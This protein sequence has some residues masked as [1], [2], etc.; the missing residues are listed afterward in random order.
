MYTYYVIMNGLDED[1]FWYSECNVLMTILANKSA[2]EAW[3]AYAEEKDPCICGDCLYADRSD[4]PVDVYRT[5]Q[6]GEVRE[7]RP[8]PAGL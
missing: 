3:K 5:H 7:D 8:V 6:R 4:Y 1:V 2:Y